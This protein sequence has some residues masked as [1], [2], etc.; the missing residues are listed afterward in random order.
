[1]RSLILLLTTTLACACGSG[2]RAGG[3]LALISTRTATAAWAE[4][5][6]PRVTLRGDLDATDLAEIAAEIEQMID[7]L[8]ATAFEFE[9]RPSDRIGVLLFTRDAEYEMGAPDDSD[10]YFLERTEPGFEMPASIFIQ[11]DWENQRRTDMRHELVHRY[12]RFYYPAAPVWLN[13]GLATFFSTLKIRDGTITL[14]EPLWTGV[15]RS[16]MPTFDVLAKMSGVDFGGLERNLNETDRLRSV[17]ANYRAAWMNVHFLMTSGGDWRRRFDVYLAALA[18]G[19]ENDAA[20]A[21][22]FEGVST[23]DVEKAMLAHHDKMLIPTLRATVSLPAAPRIEVRMLRDA[24]VDVIRAWYRDWDETGLPL[25]QRDLE[26]AIAAEPNYADAYLW[27]G[28]LAR[29][30]KNFAAARADYRR[31]RELDPRSTAAMVAELDLALTDE[32]LD[33]ARVDAILADLAKLARTPIALETVARALVRRGKNGAALGFARRATEGALGCV[34][35]WRTRAE[36]SW[37]TGQTEAAVAAM[38]VAIRQTRR[39]SSRHQ[40]EA[41]RAAMMLNPA[42]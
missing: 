41:R 34:R 5:S 9:E 2:G 25:S 12:V 19:Q 27:R 16:R 15:G 7:A 24:E 3:L 38:D 13:E 42:K 40:L 8:E 21:R 33:V 26:R 6:G 22:G 31:A 35:C 11:G 18:Q 20:W 32:D 29:D 39:E 36:V 17:R 4:A 37:S 1:M 23:D 10:A 14:G 30:A 28:H